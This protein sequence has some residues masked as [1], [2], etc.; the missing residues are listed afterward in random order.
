MKRNGFTLI[1]LI[2]VILILAVISGGIFGFIGRG[3]E[4]YVDTT[5]REQILSDSRFL[6][7]RITRELRQALPNS[8]REATSGNYQ[9]VEFVPIKW[10]SFYLDVP[11]A[12]EVASN[13][14][15]AIPLGVSADGYTYEAGDSAVVFP[16]G[17][18]QVYTDPV[19]GGGNTF[20]TGHRIQM[21]SAT[22]TSPAG[23]LSLTLAS[24][25]P[26][27]DGLSVFRQDS[28]AS[29][30]YI[31]GQPVSYCANNLTNQ[32]MRHQGYGFNS[33]QLVNP[34]VGTLMA[35]H[36]VNNFALN[37]PFRVEE[38]VLTRNAVVHIRLLFDRLEEQVE[39]NY[40][41]HIPNAP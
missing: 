34:N 2:T 24:V 35:E 14:I 5:E 13:T 27:N 17:L 33:T 8:V 15:R 12:P 29:R 9:C 20:L 41:V 39:F 6:I 30:L 36:L 1:E 28:P 11:V 26:N 10:S 7:E 32:V 4:I 21:G 31:V 23:I 38:A 19:P 3:A 22:S 18:T 40:E 25:P 37:P 16:S